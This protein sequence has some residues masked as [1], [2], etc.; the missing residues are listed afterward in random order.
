MTDDTGLA[1]EACERGLGGPALRVTGQSD[2]RRHESSDA[3]CLDPKRTRPSHPSAD[4]YT[5]RVA[6]QGRRHTR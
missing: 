4:P 6:K 3:G 2:A 5:K 1:T